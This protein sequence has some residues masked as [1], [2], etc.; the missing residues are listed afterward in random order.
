MKI[1]EILAGEDRDAQ[2]RKSHNIKSIPLSHI[3]TVHNPEEDN[4]KVQKYRRDIKQGNHI[5]PV[6]VRKTKPGTWG[7]GKYTLTDGHHRY[8]A[9]KAEGKTHI[10][11]AFPKRP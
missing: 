4:G 11:V 8:M 7:P 2:I 5:D 9:H 6:Q 10:R 1:A 3:N